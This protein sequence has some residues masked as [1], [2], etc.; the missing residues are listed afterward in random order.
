VGESEREKGG[1][2]M[3]KAKAKYKP[4]RRLRSR[5]VKRK[6]VKKQTA[7]RPESSEVVVSTRG[8]HPELWRDAD[9]F[10]D[11]CYQIRSRGKRGASAERGFVLDEFR[12]IFDCRATCDWHLAQARIHYT[13]AYRSHKA[14][15]KEALLSEKFL[16]RFKASQRDDLRGFDPQMVELLSFA[17]DTAE[18]DGTMA[19][20]KAVK[21]KG[22]AAGA[23]IAKKSTACFG[24]STSRFCRWMGA[25]GYSVEQ[26]GRAVKAAG[27]DPTPSTIA[28]GV[29]DGRSA[30]KHPDNPVYAVPE[31]SAEQQKA[32]LA[33]IG[34]EAPAGKAKKAKA[35]KAEPKKATTKKVATKKVKKAATKSK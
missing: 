2:A 6:E 11:E 33:A 5:T 8:N 15:G 20:K 17:C 19:G 31:L 28:T 26:A 27:L 35:A 25:N 10:S 18:G 13:L 7:A 30:S 22:K 34:N 3:A 9:H 32:A 4:P 1:K 12:R 16:H 21:G 24:T 14:A 29:S 23:G